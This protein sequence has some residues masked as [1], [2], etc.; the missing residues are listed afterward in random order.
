MLQAD[1]GAQAVQIFD[2]WA[3]ELSPQDFDVFAGPYIKQI[4]ASVREVRVSALPGAWRVY[5]LAVLAGWT[6]TGLPVSCSNPGLCSIESAPPTLP[7]PD[8]QQQHMP[9]LPLATTH[10]CLDTLT[11][12]RSQGLPLLT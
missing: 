8:L 9:L 6:M 12:F 10:P 11:C 3:S 2:S 1:A 4:I 5:W 7:I